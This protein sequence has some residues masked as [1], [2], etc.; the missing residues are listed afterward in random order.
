MDPT[1]NVAV[2]RGTSRR[3]AVAEALALIAPEIR[4]HITPQ[5]LIKPNLV[6]HRVQLPSTHADTLS[7]TLDA[8]LHAG[9][10][11]V[12]VAEGASDATVGFRRFGYPQET[13]GRPVEY[14]DLNR[15]ET[16]WEPLQLSGV[17]GSVLTARLSRTIATAG[18]RVSLALAKTHV[19]S[20]VTLSLKNMLSSIHPA[21]RIMMHGHSGGGNGYRGWK[22]PIVEFLKGDNPTVNLLTRTMG[23]VKNARNALREI[24]L[25]GSDPFPALKSSELDYLRSV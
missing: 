25:C 12:I 7:A 9:A 11:R 15:E 16:V 13:W 17:D 23:R 4:A 14:L 21:D 6:S 18:F 1:V 8:L 22:R 19:T 3:G 10:R 24:A 5:V 20:M 2:V